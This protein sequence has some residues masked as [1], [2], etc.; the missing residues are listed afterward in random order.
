MISAKQNFVHRIASG[1]CTASCSRSTRIPR[2]T[3]A[4]AF[5]WQVSKTPTPS[6][7]P[8]R[9][10]TWH[11]LQRL[12]YADL[13]FVPAYIGHH[14]IKGGGDN[15]WRANHP[16]AAFTSILWNPAFGNSRFNCLINS[17]GTPPK[18]IPSEK[19]ARSARRNTSTRGYR[20]AIG[21]LTDLILWWRSMRRVTS[22]SQ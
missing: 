22:S 8:L 14:F 12:L 4:V 7:C 11:F 20:L 2:K 17:A 19:S 1:R 16:P 18:I 6:T 21:Y 3:W 9:P 10:V 13:H 5:E 15:G